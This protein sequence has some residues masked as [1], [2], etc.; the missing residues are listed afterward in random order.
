MTIRRE[1]EF[2]GVREA[3]RVVRR[4]LVEMT[5]HVRPGVTTAELDDVA[6]RVFRRLRARSAPR[7]VYGFPGEVCIS[8]NEEIVH[9]IPSDRALEEGDLVKLDVT[10]EKQGY[11][12]DA[13]ITLGVGR[14]PAER[15]AL[16][17]CSRRAFFRAMRVARAGQRVNALGREIESETK[18]G[19]FTV[20]RDLTGHGI[21]RTIHE[22]PAIP[23]YDDPRARQPLVEGM[24]LAVE[25]ILCM[26][27]G[28]SETAKDGWTVL[29][30]D[31]TLAAHYEQTI[32]IT[33]EAPIIV[34]EVRGAT[35]G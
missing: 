32:V 7:L 30:S 15:Q 11:M 33:A 10:V 18:A 20:V 14:L 13:A 27:S 5:D 29:T 26:G 2:I 23:N 4:C 34:T 9:G 17:D 16:I 1:E 8:V 24:V 21:G 3:G 28:E 12:A 31:R 35:G 19:G 22:P 6:G 25:P